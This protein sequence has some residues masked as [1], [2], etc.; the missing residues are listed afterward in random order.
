[1]QPCRL[2]LRGRTNLRRADGGPVGS[3]RCFIA[4]VVIVVVRAFGDVSMDA[5]TV[6]SLVDLSSLSSLFRVGADRDS[7]VAV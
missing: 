1:M 4:S 3:D 6:T 2:E 5:D 7:A